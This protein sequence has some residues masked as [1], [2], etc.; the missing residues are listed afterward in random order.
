MSYQNQLE[1]VEVKR[2]YLYSWIYLLG[3][4][5]SNPS[6]ILQTKLYFS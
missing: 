4:T 3:A 1:I 6:N 2:L 5:F